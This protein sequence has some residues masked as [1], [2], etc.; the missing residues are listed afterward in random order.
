MSNPPPNNPN[1]PKKPAA[2]NPPTGKIVPSGKPVA[3]QSVPGAKPP[4]PKPAAKKPAVKSQAERWGEAGTGTRKIG[5]VLIDLG[6]LDEGQVWDILEEAR[7]SGLRMGQVALERGLIT[8]EQLMAAVA[9]QAGLRVVNLEDVKSTPAAIA[10]VPD[11]MANLYKVLPIS[12]EDDVLTVAM[13][14]PSNIPALD[15]LK[16]FLGIRQVTAQL[17]PQKAIEE[18][19]TKAYAGKEESIIDIIQAL[20]ADTSLGSKHRETSIDLESLMEIQ[21]AAPVRK[22]IN[23]VLLLA[24]KDQAS[25][26]HFEPFEEE[27]KMRYRCDG[28]LYEMVPPPRHLAMAIASRIK[29]MSNLDIAERRLPQD[30]RI[31]LNVGGNQVDMRVSVLPTM[32][33]ESVVIRVLDRTRVG[34]ELAKIGMPDHILTEFRKVIR[35]PNGITLVT[36]PTGA[37]KTTTLYSALN[38]LNEVTDKI[39]TTEDPVEYEIDGIVQC[40]INH[41]IDLTFASAL[42]AIL[43]QDPDII[44]VGEIR[45]LETA[46]IAIQASLTGHMVFSTLHTNDAP[47]TITR[48]RDMGVEPFL[49][50][51]TIEA[52]MAQRL[53]RKICPK[54]KVAYDPTPDQ[55]MELNYKA[56]MLKGRKFFYGE[57]C[58]ACNNLGFRGRTGIYEL[59]M[60]TDEL[61][62]MIS[63]GASTDQLRGQI[64]NKGVYSLRDAGLDAL[65]NGVTTLDEVVRETVSDEEA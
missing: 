52:I 56:E 13:A 63:A 50:T 55:L 57:G 14:D 49:L 48:M 12:F 38:E 2:G 40:P 64:R 21:D 35:K 37:G 30:G 33:G 23:M 25:D 5:Q 7:A 29:V 53:V 15:D 51:A 65:F 36:G 41:D 59:L 10:K 45:D 46:Q 47:S 9:E 32:F 39:I 62:D 11:T 43:R 58:D 6:F 17:A 20:E 34:L 27:Y 28:V 4:A 61:R 24:I 42:R 44:L 26:I 16:N 1:P 54:C 31:E 8:E 22:L 60:M 18:A 3:K 19:I